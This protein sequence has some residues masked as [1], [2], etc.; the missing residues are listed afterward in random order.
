M[1]PSPFTDLPVFQP[2]S[3]ETTYKCNVSLTQNATPPV[4]KTSTPRVPKISCQQP[5]NQPLC[6]VHLHQNVRK[7]SKTNP[8]PT[9]KTP[10]KMDSDRKMETQKIPQCA[11]EGGTTAV[12][13][14]GGAT[15]A[16]GGEGGHGGG[17]AMVGHR[18][19]Q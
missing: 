18:T 5:L 19:E 12:L 10:K 4:R 16:I 14:R 17:S 15:P 1:P 11:D 9:G 3:M 13:V 2:P 8:N 7:C 6:E